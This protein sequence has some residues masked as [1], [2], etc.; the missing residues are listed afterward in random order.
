MID[1][2]A[3]ILPGIDDG[4]VDME[5]SIEM[6]RM[7][8]VSGVKY[9]VATPHCNIPRTFENYRD[10][11]LLRLYFEMREAVKKADI[12]IQIVLGMEIYATDELPILLE[13]NKVIGLNG[14]KYLL[15]EF[16]FEEDPAFCRKIL[17]KCKDLG[18]MVIIAH[19]ERYGF[20]QRNPE[21][22]FEWYDLGYH[23][24][25][26]KGSILGRFGRKAKI[27]AH[28]LLHERIACCVASDAHSSWRRTPHMSE[29]RD[30]LEARY[31]IY[32][33]E[34]LLDKNPRKILQG[35]PL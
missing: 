27:M 29:V 7:A 26:N 8:A 21:I 35:I 34:I 23:L 4:A 15:I 17:R 24:Q 16:D 19:P 1:I 14:T 33:T 13:Q 6:A 30:Y 9:L 28:N 25:L 20:V 32:Y 31:G 3:H 10:E 2:H 12:P 22:A 5:A 18:Y 11:N